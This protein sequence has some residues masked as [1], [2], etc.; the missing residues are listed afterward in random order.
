MILLPV[1]ISRIVSIFSEGAMVKETKID[2]FFK[3]K[4]AG[5]EAHEPEPPTDIA[6]CSIMYFCFVVV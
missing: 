3:R 4:R 5:F 6:P 2:S 1:L